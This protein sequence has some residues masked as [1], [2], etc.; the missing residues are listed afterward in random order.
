MNF[1]ENAGIS[2]YFTGMALPIFCRR[3]RFFS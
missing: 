1:W 3:E 2:D